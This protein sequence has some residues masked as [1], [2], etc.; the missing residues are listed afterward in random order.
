MAVLVQLLHDGTDDVTRIGYLGICLHGRSHGHFS[1]MC[2]IS[3]TL[4]ELVNLLSSKGKRRRGGVY[5]RTCDSWLMGSPY[6]AI[7]TNLWTLKPPGLYQITLKFKYV[8]KE[9]L[10]T[11]DE[12]KT[13]YLNP[14][15]DFPSACASKSSRHQ[16]VSPHQRIFTHL[17]LLTVSNGSQMNTAQ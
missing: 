9:D 3:L 1:S 15:I 7:A 11:M 5:W 16:S 8:W 17:L 2:I 10:A 6:A 13:Y 14:G 12:I 4:L